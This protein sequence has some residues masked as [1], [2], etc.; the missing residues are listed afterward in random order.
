MSPESPSYE[1]FV[2]LL[3]RHEAALRRFVRTLLPAWSD[4]DEV[5]QRVAL[6]AWRKF[7][8]FKPD[9]DFLRWALV[10]ARF[11]AMAFRRAMGRDRLVFSEEFLE[12]LAHEAADESELAMRE[13]MALQGCLKKL[14][15]ERREIVLQAYA[16]GADQRILAGALG[17]SPA[18]LYMLLAR[19]RREL[20]ACIERALKL[21]AQA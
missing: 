9:T 5:M 4:V 21:E 16:D 15:P 2:G 1:L 14:S 11:E 6:V 3:T 18:A 19:I 7:E 10:I 8:Q 20:A 12:R 13:E 17:K